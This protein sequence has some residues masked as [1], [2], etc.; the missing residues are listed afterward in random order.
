MINEVVLPL[1]C[2]AEIENMK[3]CCFS[4]SVRWKLLL[5][6]AGGVEVHLMYGHRNK[7]N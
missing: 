2:E 1:Y 7:R 5:S 4:L 6:L 3:K